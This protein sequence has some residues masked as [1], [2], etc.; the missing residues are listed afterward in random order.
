VVVLTIKRIGLTGFVG[1]IKYGQEG[2][3]KKSVS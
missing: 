1:Q 3:R 2:R